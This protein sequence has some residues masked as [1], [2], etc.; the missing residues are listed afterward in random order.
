M[1]KIAGAT[2][3]QLPMAW[4]HN[5]ANIKSAIDLA[6]KDKVELLCLPELS[7]SGY[8]C[9]DMFLSP[10]LAQKALDLS[11]QVAHYAQD[12]TVAFGL[13][14]PMHGKVYNV[15]CVA[16]NGK[17]QCFVA[18][19]FMAIDGVHYEFRWFQP[20][21]RNVIESLKIGTN[22]YPIGDIVIDVKGVK[23]GFEIC[24]DAWRGAF[25]PGFALRERKVD[26]ILNPSASHFALEKTK[27]RQELINRS[28]LEFNCVYLY[29]NLLGNESGRMIYD[30]EIIIA[31][32]G[33]VLAQNDW[34]SMQEVNVLSLEIDFDL[35]EKLPQGIVPK[36]LSRN[37]EFLK[38]ETLGLYDYLRKSKG[39]GFVISLSGGA[40]SATCAVLVSEMVKRACAELGTETFLRN[41]LRND[42]IA[43]N[44]S[45]TQITG[46]LLDCIYQATENSSAETFLAAKELAQSIGA[47]FHHISIQDELES[48]SVKVEGLLGRKLSWESDDIAMQNIQARLRSPMAWMLANIRNALLITTS[49]RSEGDVGYTTMDGDSSGSIAPIS[50]IDKPFIRQWLL[51]A[52]KELGLAGLKRVNSQTPSAELRPAA[53]NQS[54]ESDLMPYDI[55]LAI[56]QLAIRDKLLP[57]AVFNALSEKAIAP[58]SDLKQYIARFF[59]LWARNQWKR[60]RTA[61]GFH[62]DDFNID[63]KTWCRFPILSSAF[64]AE[65]KELGF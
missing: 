42:L 5:I 17:I 6:R 46:H 49:N 3:N 16:T 50:G 53:L 40:D 59:R 58:N 34:L 10:W 41:I 31:G 55:L 24:E 56:E 7:L 20:W 63:P 33:R 25:R 64:E 21:P 23:V 51:W 12:I 8:G 43:G 15:A 29:A 2:L 57:I 60:E 22:E 48:M 35:K 11:E 14:V 39:R 47:T 4:E 54:D 30:G 26:L 18:K 1:L 13:P 45:D 19:Q 9:E 32:N 37:E 27:L 62:I 44:L 28:T 61:P 52:E 38:A 65:L 36:E